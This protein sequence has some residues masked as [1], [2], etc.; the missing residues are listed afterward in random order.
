MQ[1]A[2]DPGQRRVAPRV[3]DLLRAKCPAGYPL[4]KGADPSGRY[5][6]GLDPV[7]A[8]SAAQGA[9]PWPADDALVALVASCS[10]IAALARVCGKSRESLRDYLRLRPQLKTRLTAAG[11]V[12]RTSVE[13][14]QAR[15]QVRRARRAQRWRDRHDPECIEYERIIAS[16]PCFYPGCT[17]PATVTDHVHPYKLDGTD[18][19]T[20]YARSCPLHN[21]RKNGTAL[22]QFLLAETAR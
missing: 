16:D 3:P 18:H 4:R 8:R 14:D 21:G 2:H 9:A 17:S 1:A 11:L 19:W 10:T 15:V 22:L 7:S 5:A 12:V 6:P 13:H 20:N